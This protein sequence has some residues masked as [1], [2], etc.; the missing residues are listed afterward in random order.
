[1]TTTPLLRSQRREGTLQSDDYKRFFS[2]P[3]MVC[4]L[5]RDWVSG[6]DGRKSCLALAAPS[7]LEYAPGRSGFLP[8]LSK[9]G[10]SGLHPGLAQ[11]DEM[12]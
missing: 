12:K 8:S 4:D 3:E 10:N 5:L 7:S 1:M 2:H 11:R 9:I 6:E